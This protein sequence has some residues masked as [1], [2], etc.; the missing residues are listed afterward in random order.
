MHHVG[1]ADTDN[2]GFRMLV[3]TQEDHDAVCDAQASDLQHAPHLRTVQEKMIQLYRAIHAQLRIRNMDLST[4][5]NQPVRFHSVANPQPGGT[6]AFQW[7]RGEREAQQVE[8]LMGRDAAY[9]LITTEI[10]HHPGIEVRLTPYHLVVEL[11]VAPTAWWDQQNFKGKIG[12]P[13]Q[14]RE[15]HTLIQNL[16]DYYR[17]GFWRGLDLNEMHLMHDK[18]RHYKVLDEW[19]KTFEPR[20]D[21]F[22][23]GIWYDVD[24]ERLHDGALVNELVGQI[25]ALYPLYRFLLWTGDNNYR[26]FYQRQNPNGD[27]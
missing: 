14:R 10:D 26:A 19:L 20:Q 11:L 17:H 21:Y 1:D 15:F 22:R 12:V 16:S 25:Q 9:N 3:F 5:G 27:A 24:D 2:W 7:L 23:V 4:H 8:R 18:F 6:L 13:A